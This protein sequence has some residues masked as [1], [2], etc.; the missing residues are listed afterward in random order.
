VVPEPTEAVVPDAVERVTPAVVSVYATRS[1]SRKSSSLDPLGLSD[2]SRRTE[3]GLGSGVIV[4]P[5][6]VIVTNH[7]VVEGATELRIVLADRREFRGRVMG[8]DPQTDVA[9]V[10]IPA[11]S[12]PVVAFGD[13]EQVRVGETVLA[14]GNSLGIG[15]TVSSGIVSAKGRAN[16]GILDDENFLQTDAAINPGNSGGPLVNLKGEVIGINTAIATRTGGFQGVGFAIPSRLVTEIVEI[17]L[18]DGKVSRGQLGVTL[19]DLTPALARAFKDG[20]EQGVIVT[21]APEKG[22]AREAG[23]RRGD[24][25]LKLD[26]RPVET[27]AELR[28]RIAMRGAG[29]KVHL[30]L[31]R[32][33]KTLDLTVHLQEAEGNG[34]GHAKTEDASG[35]EELAGSSSGIEGV[36][37]GAVS[38]EL[39][40]KAGVE[41]EGGVIVISGASLLRLDGAA[42][43]RPDRGSRPESRSLLGRA[44][45]SGAAERQS[46]AAPRPP[47][48]RH[49]LP[50]RLQVGLPHDPFEPPERPLDQLRL[51]PFVNH[52][53]PGG[54]AAARG[55]ADRAERPAAR[56]PFERGGE[57]AQRAHVRRLLL[58]PDDL[59]GLRE[60][61]Q[62]G[63]QLGGGKGIE[64]LD[65]HQRDARVAAAIPLAA[66][67]V[68]DLS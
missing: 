34:A 1:V 62:R 9:L 66:E 48:R 53:R 43:R 10:R 8:C 35:S 14:M 37:V 44:S 58:D 36:G 65:R 29:A 7:H 68:S 13:S 23:I 17:L 61:L 47:V 31:W 24:I 49:S 26:G 32:H 39:L 38:P 16:I 54:G 67:I 55:A 63:G 20:P 6:G 27:S 52:G 33:G 2:S 19:Q 57:M 50:V 4:R 56:N 22:A 45:R 28:H 18:R 60:R 12:L 59:P 21:D 3:Q 64:L 42:P 41:E 11:E 15:Q 40:R 51:F 5:D 25:I 46:G 30:E